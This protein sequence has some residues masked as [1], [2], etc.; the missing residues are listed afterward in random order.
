MIVKRLFVSDAT[1][2]TWSREVTWEKCPLQA[3]DLSDIRFVFAECVSI[4][5]RFAMLFLTVQFVSQ[6]NLSSHINFDFDAKDSH[7]CSNFG[8]PT[9][10]WLV[11]FTGSDM[12][13]TRVVYVGLL[14]GNRLFH[15][16]YRRVTQNPIM[17]RIR[18]SIGN[19][20]FWPF[21][22]RPLNRLKPKVARLITSSMSPSES[23]FIDVG[24]GVASPKWVKLADCELLPF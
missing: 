19:G 21:T 2:D 9:E 24:L 3:N 17:G 20:H 7:P 18:L 15:V 12:Q 13:Y 22:E 5:C 8:H 4:I 16:F 10:T 14:T 1:L 11:D 6:F 23:R